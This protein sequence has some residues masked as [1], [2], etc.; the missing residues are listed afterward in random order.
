M[1]KAE[2]FRRYR[3]HKNNEK[4]LSMAFDSPAVAKLADFLQKWDEGGNP[5]NPD[6]ELELKFLG[7]FQEL[8]DKDTIPN[9]YAQDRYDQLKDNLNRF[10]DQGQF[11]TTTIN[12]IDTALNNL[13]GKTRPKRQPA[14]VKWT[15]NV[16]N[17]TALYNASA[18]DAQNFELHQLQGQLHCQN[19]T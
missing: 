17:D 5:Q 12:S 10:R 16:V 9:Q 19:L 2:A 8:L 14:T 3:Q 1:V 13:E 7:A 6:E 4:A 11:Y 18:S 15:Y